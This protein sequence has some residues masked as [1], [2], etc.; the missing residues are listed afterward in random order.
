MDDGESC[1]TVWIYLVPLNGTVKYGMV[2]IVC[3]LLCDFYHSKKV[4]RK[5]YYGEKSITGQT[6]LSLK[7]K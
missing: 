5:D 2:K 3:F 7:I 6:H 1:T 4:K